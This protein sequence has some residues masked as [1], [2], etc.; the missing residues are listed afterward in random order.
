MISG[1][2]RTLLVGILFGFGM[3]S[4]LEEMWLLAVVF[5]AASFLSLWLFIRA[6]LRRCV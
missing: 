5:Y 3:G 6:S 2:L 4:G 1:T